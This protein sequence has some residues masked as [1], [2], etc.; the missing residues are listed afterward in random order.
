MPENSASRIAFLRERVAA[1]KAGGGPTA[2]VPFRQE[3]INLPQIQVPI[4]FPLYRVRNGRTHRAQAAYIEQH[5][6]P[7]DFFD[8][9]ESE[10]AQEAQGQILRK[11]IDQAGLRTDLL[12]REQRSP[13][14]LTYDGFIVDGNRRT[15]ALRADG[16]VE[17]VT[18]VVLPED[19][20]ALDLY[21][22]ELEMQMARDTKAKYNW[23]DEALHVRLGIRDLSE[24]PAAIARRM[25]VDVTEK[26]IEEI[27][28]RL[29]L[30]DLYLGWLGVPGKYHRVPTDDRSAAEQ[31]FS[32]LYQRERRQSFLSFP[33]LHQRAVRNACFVVIKE[34][35]GYMD[36]RRVADSLIKHPKQV[37]TRL[38]EELPEDLR[39]RLDEPVTSGPAPNDGERPAGVLEQLAVIDLPA[40]VPAGAEILN[41]VQDASQTGAVA[42]VISRIAEDLDLLEKEKKDQGQPLRKVQGALRALEEVSLG[43]HTPDLGD[44][45]NRL[46]LI[47]TRA[48]HLAKRIDE[49]KSS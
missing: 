26:D 29:S 24:S 18:A 33:E 10:E 32:D 44:I 45:A 12:Q 23:V 6:L 8:D 25:G 37:I 9:P 31:S 46:A 2:P 41:L 16:K 48:D 22:T 3:Q 28:G 38:K 7:A 11:M 14:V 27:L 42:P 17:H 43:A 36:V 1:A 15:A 35:G 39:A 21:D 20:T 49:L 13:L 34:N 5:E 19:C 47:I 4:N 30:V 40:N